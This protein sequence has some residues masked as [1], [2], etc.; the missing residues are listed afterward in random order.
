VK[1]ALVHVNPNSLD[2]K[3]IFSTAMEHLT[4]IMVRTALILRRDALHL[5]TIDTLTVPV[6]HHVA[7][8]IEWFGKMI[9]VSVM[10]LAFRAIWTF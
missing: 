4:P 2:S 1:L 6:C 8:H 7:I 9:Q 5:V 10:P 3:I